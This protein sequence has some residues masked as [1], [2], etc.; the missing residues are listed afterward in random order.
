MPRVFTCALFHSL[1]Q[2]GFCHRKYFSASTSCRKVFRA[3]RFSTDLFKLCQHFAHLLYAGDIF[4]GVGLLLVC[5]L[6]ELVKK[7]FP[8]F[9]IAAGCLVPAFRGGPAQTNTTC[10]T[11]PR[12]RTIN[13]RLT[14][15]S[16][17]ARK[18][19]IYQYNK[20][21]GN[22]RPV[23]LCLTNALQRYTCDPPTGLN[24]LL[25]GLFAE[26]EFEPDTRHKFNKYDWWRWW[27]C[28]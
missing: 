28:I 23:T 15:R 20:H 14:E 27:A 2:N 24:G 11:H 4:V 5:H 3:C 22:A 9:L 13:L 17:Y 8:R 7:R 10:I 21:T 26:K 6:S 12:V 1:F 19:I 25:F 16:H 18:L